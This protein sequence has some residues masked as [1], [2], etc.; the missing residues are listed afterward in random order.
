MKGAA[1]MFEMFAKITTMLGRI[2]SI[3]F[4]RRQAQ[5]PAYTEAVS[6]KRGVSAAVHDHLHS[7]WEDINNRYFGGELKPLA[8]GW[9]GI[10][11]PE[12]IGA[13]GKFIAAS[14]C[15]IIDEKF[16]FDEVAIQNGS[17]EEERKCEQTYRLLI[18]EMIHQAVHQR[19]GAKGGH[20]PTWPPFI[21]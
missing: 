16:R 6:E 10:S 9:G 1:D 12:G 2:A 21:Y 4:D 11:G 20:G 13:H 17:E 3:I 8:I 5:Q 15:I 19:T 14:R 18:H 7:M